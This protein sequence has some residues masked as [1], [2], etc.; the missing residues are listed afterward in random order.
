MTIMQSRNPS[1]DWSELY[2]GL[3]GVEVDLSLFQIDELHCIRKKD[4][5]YSVTIAISPREGNGD[6]ITVVLSSSQIV[7]FPITEYVSK[8]VFV[9]NRYRKLSKPQP[10]TMEIV[11]R[12]GGRD[13]AINATAIHV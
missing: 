1:I 11:N 5:E 3:G 13:V 4:S 10:F 9:N 6:A 8:L 2:S 7:W 12:H